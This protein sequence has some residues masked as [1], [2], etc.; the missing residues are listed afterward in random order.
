MQMH[1]KMH[2]K[3]YL[4]TACLSKLPA[5]LSRTT[6]ESIPAS[7]RGG[8][9]HELNKCEVEGLEKHEKQVWESIPSHWGIDLTYGGMWLHVFVRVLVMAFPFD[10][11][12]CR[13]EQTLSMRT[14]SDTSCTIPSLHK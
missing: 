13:L 12:R 4:S 2:A 7:D 8:E 5:C 3:S 1:M 10:D 14:L 9:S 11:S 6:T